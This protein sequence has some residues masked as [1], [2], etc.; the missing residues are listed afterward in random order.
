MPGGLKRACPG[1]GGLC[2]EL[3]DSGRLCLRHAAEQGS[4]RLSRTPWRR[5]Y[6]RRWQKARKRFLRRHPVCEECERVGQITEAKVVDHRIP[7][8]GDE[9]LFW[10]ET[11]WSALCKPHHDVKSARFDG[12]FGR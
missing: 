2:P 9:R 11:N 7:H 4:R 12:R 3:V 6:D 8:R 5:L 10:D 1:D